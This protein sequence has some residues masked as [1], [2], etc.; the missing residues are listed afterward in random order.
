MRVMRTYLSLSL[1]QCIRSNQQTKEPYGAKNHM[2]F[3]YSLYIYFFL[4]IFPFIISTNYSYGFL[5][6]LRY[7]GLNQNWAGKDN[8]RIEQRDIYEGQ[9][10]REYI[11]V[12]V[13]DMTMAIE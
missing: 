7:S 10:G 1:L 5:L 13:Y 12:Y 6:L 9:I 4:S 11:Y 3:C 2:L 8:F